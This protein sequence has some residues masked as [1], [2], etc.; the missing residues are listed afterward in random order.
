MRQLQS[1]PTTIEEQMRRYYQSLSE[2][3]RRRYVGIEALK[4]G[5]GGISYI[6]RVLGCNRETIQLGIADL[7]DPVAMKETRQRE[8]G[9]GRK[10]A[11]GVRPI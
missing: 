1:Y 2:K 10:R 9:G 7:S 11:P 6:H 4:L 8:R 3:D 5:Y